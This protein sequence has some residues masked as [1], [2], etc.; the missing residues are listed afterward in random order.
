M[1]KGCWADV[2]CVEQI[3]SIFLT[4]NGT[5]N[6]TMVIG[7][8]GNVDAR[9]F[10]KGADWFSDWKWLRNN[11]LCLLSTQEWYSHLKSAHSFMR[12][13]LYNSDKVIEVQK[14]CINWRGSWDII[15]ELHFRRVHKK[16][17]RRITVAVMD[18]IISILSII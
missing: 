16:L 13:N 8:K 14:K 5:Q 18:P 9:H 7:R 17:D 3:V 12:A 4:I 15:P 10:L 1:L 11:I 2:I 6:G